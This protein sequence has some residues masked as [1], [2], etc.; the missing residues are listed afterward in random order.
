MA[1]RVP[2]DVR[3]WTKV[4]K[5]PGRGCW[6]W[7]AG[8]VQGSGYGK[9]RVGAGHELAHRFSYKLSGR[10]IPQHHFVLHHCDNKRCVRPDHLYAGTSVENIRDAFARGRLNGPYASKKRKPG[11]RAAR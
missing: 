3:F 5:R 2:D 8:L 9:F 6:E 7:L 1:M 4:K 10:R 11:A